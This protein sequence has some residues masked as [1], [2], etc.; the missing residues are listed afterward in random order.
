MT[1]LL[2]SAFLILII[3]LI[4]YFAR[5]KQNIGLKILIVFGI[6]IG[7]VALGLNSLFDDSFGASTPV[8]IRTEN[9]T[10]KNLKVYTIAFWSNNWNGNGN[11]VTYDKKLKPNE[12]SDFW[13]E[14]DAMTEFWVVAKNEN[15][16]IEYLNVVT[17][18][19]SEFD[20]KIT[21]EKM[22]DQNKVQIANELTAKK[23]R[24]VQMEIF[25]FWTNIVLIGLLILS[26]IKNKNW[27]QHRL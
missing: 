19:E 5:K 1:I 12:K 26:L 4:K 2:F 3:L 20:F 9:L 6:I 8:N 7:L 15:N 18:Q 16:G 21:E 22:F 11:Y 17:E 10:D 25:A 24:S 27:W 23:D 13:F 14:N